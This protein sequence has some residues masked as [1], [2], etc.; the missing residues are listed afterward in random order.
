[1]KGD[2]ELHCFH[3]ILPPVRVPDSAGCLLLLLLVVLLITWLLFL[4]PF[5]QGL[6]AVSDWSSAATSQQHP[7]NA[8]SSSACASSWI[9]PQR[10]M[11]EQ[12]IQDYATKEAFYIFLSACVERSR[13]SFWLCLL[14]DGFS[15]SGGISYIWRRNN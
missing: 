3:P 5:P 11:R 13:Q 1:M 7:G 8:K 2:L 6:A 4:G 9:Q 14:G 12:D 10:Q 15:S